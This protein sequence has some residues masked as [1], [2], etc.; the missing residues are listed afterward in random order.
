MSKCIRCGADLTPDEVALHKKLVN[1]GA[2]EHMCIQCC[3][4][5]FDV[6]VGLLEQKIEQFK[7]SGCT[8]FSIKHKI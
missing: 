5:Y 8:L 4:K 2:K 6:T 3:A 1:G 7:K